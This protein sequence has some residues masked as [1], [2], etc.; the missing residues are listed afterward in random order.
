[1][2]FDDFSYFIRIDSVA[3]NGW[4]LKGAQPTKS[5]NLWFDS[6]AGV[7]TEIEPLIWHWTSGYKRLFISKTR[8]ERFF[9][10]G[11]GAFFAK[12]KDR[13]RSPIPSLFLYIYSFLLISRDQTGLKKTILGERADPSIDLGKRLFNPPWKKD[14]WR[15]HSRRTL[16]LSSMRLLYLW[17]DFTPALTG[18]RTNWR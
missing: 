8:T 10:I 17:V 6:Q 18:K 9:I 2:G 3:E 7:K 15:L 1:M 14:S 11:V 5:K 4:T 12:A 16:A 13:V